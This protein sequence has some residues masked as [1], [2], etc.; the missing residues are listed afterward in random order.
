MI[1][2]FDSWILIKNFEIL[3]I[4]QQTKNIAKV[5]NNIKLKIIAIDVNMLQIAK[6]RI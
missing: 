6:K 1:S 3:N 2:R 5:K 4:R